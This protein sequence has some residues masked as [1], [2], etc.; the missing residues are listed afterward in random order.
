M[1]MRWAVLA[2]LVAC[3]SP[4][5]R[6]PAVELPDAGVSA[7]PAVC[8]GDAT[9][10][11]TLE[12]ICDVSLEVVDGVLVCWYSPTCHLLWDELPEAPGCFLYRT[13]VCEPTPAV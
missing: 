11:E 10:W 7:A 12:P 3:S 6:E 5:E 4:M 2:L 9:L 13:A 8:P 1:A